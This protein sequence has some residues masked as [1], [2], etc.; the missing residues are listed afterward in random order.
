MPV[1]G[2]AV[3]CVGKDAWLQEGLH[4]RGASRRHRAVVPVNVDEL[5]GATKERW[6]KREHQSSRVWRMARGNSDVVYFLVRVY[7]W[8]VE[9]PGTGELVRL[10][11]E[12]DQGSV[13][14]SC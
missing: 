13:V 1:D 4:K 8:S 7:V 10:S 9:A 14:G 3:W 11:A 5:K 2:T 6:P 12:G